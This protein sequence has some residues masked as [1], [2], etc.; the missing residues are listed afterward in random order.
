MGVQFVKYLWIFIL[1]HECEN[2]KENIVIKKEISL[3]GIDSVPERLKLNV[4]EVFISEG[5]NV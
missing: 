3:D 4:V 2:E 1:F 5:L